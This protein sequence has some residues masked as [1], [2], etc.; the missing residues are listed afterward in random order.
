MGLHVIPVGHPGLV[1]H[2]RGGWKPLLQGR[3][4]DTGV[5][6]AVSNKKTVRPGNF[7]RFISNLTSICIRVDLDLEFAAI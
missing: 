1:E 4:R 2:D 7:R 3:H 6:K 5:K